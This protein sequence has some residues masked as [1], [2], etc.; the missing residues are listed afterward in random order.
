MLFE[1][2]TKD[3]VLY[4]YPGL[5]P[6]DLLV[7]REYVANSIKSRVTD[8][9]TGRPILPKDQLKHGAYY[10][11][12]CRNASVARWNAEQNC[13][14]HWRE[15]FGHIYIETIKYPTD[16]MEPWWDVF[17]I[18]EELPNPKVETPFDENAEFGGTGPI[19]TSTTKRC[20]AL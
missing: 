15:K 8:E 20:G 12:R 16:E 11:G 6:E 4:R 9:F 17:D 18:A 19:C 3:A 14:F 5:K 7:V 1:G 10:K 2:L 13:F